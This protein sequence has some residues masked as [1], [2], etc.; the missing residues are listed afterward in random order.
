M[1]GRV[2]ACP[3]NLSRIHLARKR[4]S[5]LDS[6][7]EGRGKSVDIEIGIIPFAEMRLSLSTQ[8]LTTQRTALTCEE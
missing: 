6:G 1:Q 5:E 2:V 3:G 4:S 7:R 8:P